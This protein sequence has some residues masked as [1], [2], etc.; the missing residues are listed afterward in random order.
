MV[1]AMAREPVPD[2]RPVSGAPPARE[3]PPKMLRRPA[4]APPPLDPIREDE[5]VVGLHEA[6]ARLH[7]VS[8]GSPPAQWQRVRG[9]V[10]R[11]LPFVGPE[12]DL[13]G[14][15]IR[16]VDALAQRCDE[17]AARLQANEELTEDVADSFGTD[18]TQLRADVSRVRVELDRST[19]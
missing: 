4:Q 5:Q 14:G 2:M 10:R 15:L 3:V 7:G 11:S 8:E 9:K 12:H 13:L 16:A 1:A 17:L 6:W 19:P 18:L